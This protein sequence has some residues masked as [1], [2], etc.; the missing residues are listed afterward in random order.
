MMGDCGL[1]GR[2]TVTDR[3]F[4]YAISENGNPLAMA[5]ELIEQ[6]GELPLNGQLGFIYCTSPVVPRLESLVSVLRS[7]LGVRDWVGTTGLG[8]CATGREFYSDAAV[9]V[10]ITDWQV[11]DY[12]LLQNISGPDL[13]DVSHL[14]GQVALIHADPYGQNME[15]MLVDLSQNL[16]QAYLLGG[17][18]SSETE[19]RLLVG[20][21]ISPQGLSGVVLGDHVRVQTGLTQGCSPLGETHVVTECQNNILISLDGR[22][23]LE[24]M[25]EE[26]GELLMRDLSRVAG[27]IFVALPI[28]QSDRG[29]YLVRNLIGIDPQKGYIAVGEML[30]NGQKLQFARRDANTARDDMTRMLDDLKQR[31]A[32]AKILGGLYISCLGRGRY[33]FGENSEELRMI[34]Q[35]LG[36]IPLVGFYAN[37]EISHDRLY[38]YTGVLTLFLA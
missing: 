10:M 30:E 33:Q 15:Q 12:R 19:N 35:S 6:L 7:R 22:P 24:V 16:G 2:T 25:S 9:V 36:D 28:A 3:R 8:I 38:G 1:G 5:D 21:T 14:Q 34:Q 29:D 17:L 23:A 27:Y 20:E 32:D 18:S 26:I 11:D 13:P 4:Y 37:G 31:S